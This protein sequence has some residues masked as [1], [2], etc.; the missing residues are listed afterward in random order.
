MSNGVRFPL[1]GRP[2]G[3]GM[4]PTTPAMQLKMMQEQH[5]Q[6]MQQQQ[7]QAQ[8]GGQWGQARGPGFTGPGRPKVVPGKAP[9]AALSMGSIRPGPQFPPAL[10]KWLQR[11]FAH[12]TQSGENDP[13][14]QKQTHAY[15]RHW[16]QQWVKTGEL[17]QRNWETALLPTPQEIRMN[18]PPGTLSGAPQTGLAASVP[19]IAI[20]ISGAP[21][22]PHMPR[23]VEPPAWR[24]DASPGEGGQTGFSPGGYNK[25][26]S[27]RDRSRSRDD[28]RR[29]SRSRR[30]RRRSTSSS[31]S[32]SRSRSRRKKS[33]DSSSEASGRSDSPP[34][35]QA[36]PSMDKGKGKG[37]GMPLVPG[38]VVGKGGAGVRELAR[39]RQ[40]QELAS[41]P[42]EE[43]RLMVKKFLDDRLQAA[44]GYGRHKELQDELYNVL[45]VSG[46]R[47]RTLFSQTLL[48]YVQSF[49]S[50]GAG[51][52]PIEGGIPRPKVVSQGEQQM[53]AQRAARFQSH[54]QVERAP[55]A[56]VSFHESD[57]ATLSGGPLVGALTDMCSREEAR[58]RE[59]TR[60]LDKLEW[61]KGTDPKNPEVNLVLATKKYQRS[62]ADKAYRSQDVR[63][64]DA[65]WRTME[66][67]MTEILDFDKNPKATFAVPKLPYIE[68][69]SYLRDRTRSCRVDL[70]LQQPRSTAQRTFIDTHECCLRFEMMSLFL[71][72]GESGGST[73]KYDE[74]L[75]LKAIS[76]TIEPLLNA[77]QA[78]RDKLLVKNILAQMM[79]D[80][81]FDEPDTEQEYSSPFEPSVHRYIVLLLMAFSPE[82]L[83]THIAKLSR[84]TLSHPLVSFATQAYAAYRTDDYGRFLRLYRTSDFLT[85]VA[86][87]G[88]ADLARLRAL[89]LLVRTYCQPV[90]DKLT[91]ARLCNILAFASE[92]H[93]KSFLAFHGVKV[94]TGAG[95][96]MVVLPKKGTPEAAQHPLLTGPAR[97]PEKCDYPKGADSM[98]VSKFEALGLTRADIVFGSADPIVEAEPQTLDVPE[99]NAQGDVEVAA[100]I[101]KDA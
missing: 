14:L 51:F 93:A 29:R 89:W 74:R 86:M 23:I 85:A 39:R 68:A 56:M 44:N 17:W 25:R 52:I 43:A 26:P 34:K 62:S 77:Y 87:S 60:Q 82:E 96:S 49:Y 80:M 15:L 69:Y 24:Q 94:E 55:V 45:G 81:A 42:P 37:K 41:K 4:R 20:S 48:Q 27:G 46:K 101:S 64:L 83:L 67:L 57:G 53:R 63:T 16:V 13:A 30:R 5:Q 18:V 66:F 33:E 92:T 59:M 21:P 40:E 9:P 78:V 75:G 88:V 2:P 99:D 12:Q 28:R 95:G 100:E 1:V 65:C 97:L 50:K 19:P 70:H 31:G 73:E 36:D 38:L 54:L 22:R 47:F 35:D 84:D 98:L 11:L 76:Q 6:R 3:G 58:E 91:L 61:K 8:S 79:G 7:T 71:L 90:G 10:Q 72:Q 32:R